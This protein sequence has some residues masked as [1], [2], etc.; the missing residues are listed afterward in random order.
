MAPADSQSTVGA[1]KSGARSRARYGPDAPW[2][3]P[4]L[5]L[6]LALVTP[7][8]CLVCVVT[9]VTGQRRRVRS[10]RIAVAAVIATALTLL[11]G[12]APGAGTLTID[13][14][15]T[16]LAAITDALGVTHPVNAALRAAGGFLGIRLPRLPAPGWPMTRALVAGVPF[17]VTFGLWLAA[18]HAAWMAFRR[19]PL[20]KFE[21]YGWERPAGFLDRRRERTSAERIRTGRGARLANN[22]HGGTV[23]VGV[24]AYGALIRCDVETFIRPTLI[25]GGPRMGKT[26]HALSLLAQAAGAG[27]GMLV[28]DFKGD[29]EI[30]VFWAQFAQ[31][32]GRR[33]LHFQTADK[34]GAPY[35]PP[36][37]GAPTQQASYDPMLRGNASS[38]T[39]MLVNSIDTTG[40]AA[41][42]HR[43]AY[44]VAQVAFAVAELTGYDMARGALPALKE[45]LDVDYLQRVADTPGKDGRPLLA[46]H[47]EIAARVTDMVNTWR[48]DEVLRAAV[49]NLHRTLSTRM[50]GP[51]VGPWLRPGP[52][53]DSTIDLVRACLEGDVVVF[54]LPVQDYGD[55]ACDIGT[56]ALLDLQ[57][58][59]TVLR[60]RLG[61]H[62]A[63]IGD[64]TAPP[65]WP[66][67]Y[68]EI[69]EF[70]SAGPTAVMDVLNKAGDVQVRPFLSTQSWNDIV[71][72]DGTGVFARRVLDQAGNI[73]CFQINDAVGAT[74]LS[75]ITP[76]VTKIM[77]RGK[78]E[79]S[80]GLSGMGLRA[81]NVGQIDEQPETVSQV[82]RSAF[83]TLGR[84][85]MVWLSTMPARATHSFKAGPNQWWETIQSVPVPPDVAVTVRAGAKPVSNPMPAA[86]LLTA[87]GA[88]A[89][90]E[91]T[92]WGAPTEAP[93]PA[94]ARQEPQ[95][96]LWDGEPPPDAGDGEEGP[97][98]DWGSPEVTPQALPVAAAVQPVPGATPPAVPAVSAPASSGR[99]APPPPRQPVVQK[100]WRAADDPPPAPAVPVSAV[101]T[102][103][104]PPVPDPAPQVASDNP[105]IPDAEDPAGPVWPVAA[106][107]EQPNEAPENDARLVT[108]P[109]PT[110]SPAPGAL[111][112]L[113]DM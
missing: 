86:D 3:F 67:M 113:D 19:R 11:L 10:H 31:A 74:A 5:L 66:P 109:A 91:I 85:T 106:D 15:L 101:P 39:D 57:N 95:Q 44:E 111:L 43:A 56:L 9:A 98:E 46:D 53:P 22:G 4:V 58:A 50:V 52:T 37:P 23:G 38:R 108:R 49:Q 17:G 100:Q 94:H 35:T 54:S 34:N 75:E 77:G 13:W 62:R 25:F 26:R 55:I 30:P 12:L 89:G 47:P 88:E 76:L 104:Q 68:V 78:T 8:G 110:V 90:E 80:G 36:I 83:Q 65:P 82:P 92:A 41:V 7:I 81:A 20:M 97:W 60:G 51:A 45:L 42:Y 59:I 40:D 103:P 71:A 27:S 24:G 79:F 1:G 61:E 28:I 33:F 69:E 32:H 72:V 105:A 112:D 96:Q 14:H 99:P 73:F 29:R 21:G 107:P 93:A 64:P 63:E 87:P 2:F 70:G 84:Y 48:K 6:V 16:S 102:P 18:G